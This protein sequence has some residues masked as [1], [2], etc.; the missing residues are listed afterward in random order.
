M[1]PVAV[2]YTGCNSE[3]TRAKARVKARHKALKQIA[4]QPL[5]LAALGHLVDFVVECGLSTTGE[6]GI[7]A[8]KYEGTEYS[9]VTDA[10]AI[11]AHAQPKTPTSDCQHDS[12]ED[13]MTCT[14][15]GQCRED[16]DSNDLCMDCG[17]VDENEKPTERKFRNDYRCPNDG[18]VWSDVWTATCNDRCPECNAEITPYNSTEI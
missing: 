12:N 10:K 14:S 6:G 7:G 15:C 13:C 5:L 9:V 2:D 11:I 17:G 16:L 3:S 8:F 1:I 18:H 4:T